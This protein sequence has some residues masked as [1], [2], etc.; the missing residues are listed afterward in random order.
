MLFPWN[1]A[2][3]LATKNGSEHLYA[4]DSVEGVHPAR[5]VFSKWQVRNNY[6]KK[7]GKT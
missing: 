2:N 1:L 6:Y 7:L 4:G 5:T 3:L